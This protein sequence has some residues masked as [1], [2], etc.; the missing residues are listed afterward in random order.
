MLAAA[1]RMIEAEYCKLAPELRLGWSFLYSPATTLSPDT[2]LMLV[3]LN[4]AGWSPR[5]PH[6][7]CEEGNAYRI[8]FWGPG[9]SHN[10][11]QSQV[12]QLYAS[13]LGELGDGFTLEHIMDRTLVANLVPFRSRSWKALATDRHA[14]LT[15]ARRLWAPI[16][17]VLRPRVVVTL[18]HLPASH[19]IDIF[20]SQGYDIDRTETRQVGWGSTTYAKTQLS[21]ADWDLTLLR[22]PH[23]SRYR[24]F[25]RP[26]SRLAVRDIAST[27]ATALCER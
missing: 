13:T 18:G 24:F 7:S 2:R 17:R 6:V 3:A 8:Q 5:P 25:G 23:L 11:L 16:L 20:V 12:Q 22:L 15:F 4:P 26:E 9:N 27:I 1:R 21:R 19:L 10:G 14:L